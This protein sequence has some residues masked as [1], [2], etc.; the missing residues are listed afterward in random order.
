MRKRKE[1]KD[2]WSIFNENFTA[3]ETSRKAKANETKVLIFIHFYRR[4]IYQL[5]E[6]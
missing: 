1:Q 3:S 6:V 2:D 4:H 5:Q